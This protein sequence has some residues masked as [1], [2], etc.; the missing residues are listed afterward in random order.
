MTL[1]TSTFEYLQPTANQTAMMNETRAAFTQL[2]YVLSRTV[3]EGPDKTHIMRSLRTVGMWANVAITRNPD[4]SPRRAI[5]DVPDY[6]AD[7][8]VEGDLGSVPT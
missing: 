1:H 5:D 4:G 7:H 6:P 3:P 2:A 8:P